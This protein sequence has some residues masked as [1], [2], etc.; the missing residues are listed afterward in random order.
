MNPSLKSAFR[1]FLIRW[2]IWLGVWTTIGLCFGHQ[3]YIHLSKAGTNPGWFKVIHWSLED[4]YVWG[5]FSLVIVKLAQRFPLERERWF[6][7]L[8]VHLAA[9]L[10][11]AP[12][13]QVVR[14]M[15]C[16]M[17][18]IV[19]R[20]PLPDLLV[21]WI[22]LAVWH[23]HYWRSRYYE[24]EMRA[25]ELERRMVQAQLLALRMQLNPHFFFNT[26]NAISSLMRR[27]LETADKMIVRLSELLRQALDTSKEQETSLEQEL[28]FLQRYIDLERLR[29]GDRLDC[30]I[31]VASNVKSAKVPSLILQPLVENAIR[32]GIEPNSRPGRIRLTVGRQNGTLSIKVSDNGGGVADP[33]RI[34]LGIGISNTRARLVGLYG[35]R[36]RFDLR[37]LPEGGF[38][39]ALEFPFHT[40]NLVAPA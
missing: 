38:E 27:D 17:S 40:E 30:E 24:R 2:G 32:H 13:Y 23:A 6:R 19:L 5:A 15:V 35:D 33:A 29:F 4:W 14:S 18:H 25:T 26:L 3:S 10:V 36:H 7:S 9:G 34:D 16:G 12:V 37:N 20:Q 1:E 31:A 8:L 22:I 39:V 21:Y 28:A 11:M